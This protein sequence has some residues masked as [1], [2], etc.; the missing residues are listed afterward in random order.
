M[1]PHTKDRVTADTQTELTENITVRYSG[2]LISSKNV[3]FGFTVDQFTAQCKY[4]YKIYKHLFIA[5][6]N[7]KLQSTVK[8][9][10]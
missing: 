7:I 3:F 5:N 4:W 6:V 9:T 1:Y 10:I 8:N 2:V